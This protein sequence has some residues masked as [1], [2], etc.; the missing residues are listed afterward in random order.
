LL[1]TALSFDAPV[2]RLETYLANTLKPN[3]SVCIA[4][5]AMAKGPDNFADS[6]V[7][8]KI[9]VSGYILSASVACTLRV[10]V[11]DDRCSKFTH[12]CEYLWGVL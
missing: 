10:N 8:S 3:Q 7:D 2:T 9:A 1:T 11:S 12:A 5:G 4:V 6:W